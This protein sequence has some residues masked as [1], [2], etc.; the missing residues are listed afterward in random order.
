MKIIIAGDGKVGSL[1]TGHLSQEGYDLT[2]V[3]SNQKVLNSTVEQH[4]VMAVHGNCASMPVLIQAGVREADLLIAATSTDEINLLCCMTA[5]GINP[6]LH[7]IGRIRN[8]DYTDQIYAM[9]DFFGLAMAV[10]PEKQAAFE[11]ERLL[12]FPG[13]LKRDTFAKG[14]VEIVELRVDEKSKLCNLPL[15]AL[16]QMVKCSVLVCAVLRD[17]VAIMPDGNFVLEDKDRVFVTASTENLTLLLKNLGIIT[18]KVR[19][20]VLCGGGRL[21][22]HLTRQLLASGIYVKVIERELDRCYWGFNSELHLR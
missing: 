12:K 20:V 11:A 2:V 19:R 14:R 1:L 10:N 18:R 17:G 6:E 3:D 16:N 7:T 13:F 15:C 4:D 9:Q 21:C 8:P 22:V 5:Q